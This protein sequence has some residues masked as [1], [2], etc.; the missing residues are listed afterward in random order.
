MIAVQT[1]EGLDAVAGSCGASFYLTDLAHFEQNCRRFLGAFRSIYPN[2][3]IGYSYKTNYL[4]YF[5]LRADA[6]GAYS[7]VVSGFEFDFARELGIPGERIIFNGPVKRA[8]DLARA[9]AAGAMVNADSISEIREMIRVATAD[10]AAGPASVGIRCYLGPETAGSRFGIDLTA[11]E[12]AEA[13]AALD[14]TPNLRLAG[15]HC[16]QSGDRSAQRYRHRTRAMISL[17]HEVLKGRPLD[18]IDIGGGFG[19]NMSPALASQL[20]YSPARFA[21]YAEA[22]AGEMRDAYADDGPALILEPGMAV[23]ADTMVFVTRVEAV[24][25]QHRRLAVVDGSVFNIQ[26]LWSILRENINLPIRVLPADHQ[27]PP[28]TGPWDVVGHTCVEIDVLHRGY[29]GPIG[30]GDYVVVENVGAYTNVLNAPFIR[31]TPAIV[32]L[33]S[34]GPRTILRPGSTARDLLRS[35]QGEA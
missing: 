5:V 2:T 31:G 26:P 30:I 22:V 13:L 24:K 11:P 34:D 8:D 10:R 25:L 18:Y 16:H 21:D 28:A 12:G 4:P 1:W 33:S 20:S 3:R 23:L 35:Y 15:L 9:F 32:E 19:G 6:L 17:H 27:T 29:E 7:E 14:A